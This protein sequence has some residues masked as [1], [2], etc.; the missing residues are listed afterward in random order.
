M[1]VI[2]DVG[3]PIWQFFVEHSVVFF[4]VLLLAYI[5]CVI[6]RENYRDELKRQIKEQLRTEQNQDKG[7]KHGS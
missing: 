7:G 4:L 2:N 5:V 3:Q 1:N 6:E